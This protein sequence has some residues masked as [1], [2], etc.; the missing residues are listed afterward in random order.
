MALTEVSEPRRQLK[1][2]GLDK[3][4]GVRSLVCPKAQAAALASSLYKQ[5]WPEA[6]GGTVPTCYDYDI[7]YA[8][9]PAGRSDLAL[10]EAYY[11]TPGFEV[12]PAG[13]ARLDTFIKER[14]VVLRRDAIT[15]KLV[16]GREQAPD[17]VNT[18]GAMVIQGDNRIL[19]YTTVYVLNARFLKGKIPY[20]QIADNKGHL[21]NIGFTKPK[22]ARGELLLRGASIGEAMVATFGTVRIHLE[23]RTGGWPNMI[24]SRP[25]AMQIQRQNV[26]ATDGV[27][28]VGTQRVHV[29]VYGKVW[30]AAG[31]LV[32]ADDVKCG[33]YKFGSFAWLKQIKIVEWSDYNYGFTGSLGQ[34]GFE[35]KLGF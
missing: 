10:V 15:G 27:T 34:R 23:H 24:T 13:H 29:P 4:S 7:I 33:G 14:M 11:S 32:K 5:S 16:S 3:W 31:V 12:L 8:P 1:R 25:Y 22:A 6:T 9:Y 35:G 17:G 26:Y 20:D 18:N 21:N 2:R 28:V 19:E 30:N